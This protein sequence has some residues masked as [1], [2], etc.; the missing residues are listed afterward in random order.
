MIQAI[1]KDHVVDRILSYPQGEKLHVLAPIDIR[2]GE[3]FES[4]VTRLRRQGYLRIRLNRNSIHLKM[5]QKLSLTIVDAKM[6]FFW[7]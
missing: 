5:N 2:K 1:S 6:T 4:I 7:L 3:S